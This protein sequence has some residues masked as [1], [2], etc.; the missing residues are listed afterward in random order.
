MF[1]FLTLYMQTVLG[2]S[3]LQ[4][5]SA[6]LPLTLTGGMSAGIAT[7]MITKLGTRPVLVAGLTITGGG[8]IY[9]SRIPVSGSYVADVLPGLLVVGAGVV[10]AF[11]AITTAGN[12]GVPADR[13][14]VAAALLNAAQQLGGALGLAVLSAIATAR[15]SHLIDRHDPAADALTAG[16]HRALLVG[17]LFVL[18]ATAFGLRTRNS[19]GEH[20]A[21]PM[22][23]EAE[24]AAVAQQT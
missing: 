15:T 8:L 14:G 3:P 20:G 4:A 9:L 7:R 16:F 19:R 5:G 13:A 1:F 23:V 18:A 11:A 10:G 12:A 21:E 22:V 17:G 24:L 6:Y 2:F